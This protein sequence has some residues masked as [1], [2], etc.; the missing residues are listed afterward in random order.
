MIERPHVRGIGG[1]CLFPEVG[2]RF[3]TGHSI[4]T[5]TRRSVKHGWVDIAVMQSHDGAQWT[6]RMPRGIPAAWLPLSR[7]VPRALDGPQ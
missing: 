1:H 3:D 5:V 7:E 6:K 2:D 4:V